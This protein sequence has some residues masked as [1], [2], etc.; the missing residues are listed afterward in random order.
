M[1]PRKTTRDHVL[2]AI[3]EVDLKRVHNERCPRC[4]ATVLELLKSLYGDVRPNHG[5]EVGTLP[6][7]FKAT[8]YYKVLKT[9]FES[10]QIRR[11]FRDFV[12]TRRLPNCDFFVPKPGFVVEF[13]ES[14]H[15]TMARAETL[16][17]YPAD[18][19][20]GFDP[21]EWERRCRQIAAEDH[22]PPYRD[23]QRAWYDTLRD[24]LPAVKGLHPTIRLYAKKFAW[25]SLDPSN[26]RDLDTFRK[27]L[28]LG[29]DFWPIQIRSCPDAVLSRV[30]I[31]GVWDGDVILA[32]AL[33]RGLCERFA[34]RAKVKCLSTCG[35]FLRFDFPQDLP[36]LEDNLNPPPEVIDALIK[37]AEQVCRQLLD[38]YTV[39]QLRSVSDYLTLGVDSRKRLVSTTYNRITERHVELVCLVDLR[40]GGHHWTGKFYPTPN[41]ER[42]IIRFTDLRS[43]FADLDFGKAMVL[44]CHDITVFN[45]RSQAKARDWRREVSEEFRELARIEKPTIVLHHPHTAVKKRTWSHAWSGVRR[46]V[47]SVKYCLGTGT[48]SMED[49]GW[50]ARNSLDDVLGSTKHG[51]VL[52]VVVRVAGRC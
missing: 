49:K 31:D 7:D 38:G 22:D 39:R 2:G 36:P 9:I 5:F 28:G 21:L 37:S 48:Y 50:S 46:Q 30:I 45:P 34:G 35:G 1:I 47:P 27:M 3:A 42:T 44:G 51:P 13:D 10:L 14:Q 41:Q 26:P 40:T 15:F 43:H 33:L 17:L 23:E 11:G 19:R 25:C 29:A 6:D 20:V 16:R 4:K 8:S 52:D 24:F 32:N 12:R 18:L